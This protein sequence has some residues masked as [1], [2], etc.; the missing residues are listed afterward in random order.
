M[1]NPRACH[2]KFAAAQAVALLQVLLNR[3]CYQESTGQTRMFAH[4]LFLAG[5]VVTCFVHSYGKHHAFCYPDAGSV[6]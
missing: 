3:L 5:G 1:G 2:Q 6:D 4:M